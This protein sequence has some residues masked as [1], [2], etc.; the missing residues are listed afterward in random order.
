MIN[1]ARTLTD[2]YSDRVGIYAFQE[3]SAGT[4][5][6]PTPVP[7]DVA[8][9]VK[10]IDNVLGVVA[11]RIKSIMVAHNDQVPA[12]VKPGHE[13]GA[14]GRLAVVRSTNGGCAP[15]RGVGLEFVG[16]RHIRAQAAVKAGRRRLPSRHDC[17]T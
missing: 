11:A 5:Y 6:E 12:P 8:S 2:S 1:E 16:P 10:S 7:K 3:N 4:G 15:G 13:P 9:R 14:G 17:R